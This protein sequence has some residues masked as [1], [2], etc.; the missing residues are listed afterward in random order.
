MDREVL[1]RAF[2][3]FFTTKKMGEGTG[4]G[5]SM[6]YGIVKQSGGHIRLESKPGEGCTFWIYLP[7]VAQVETDVQAPEPPPKLPRGSETILLAEDEGGVRKL[8]ST[9]LRD[10]GY[11]VLTAS[12]GMAGIGVAH[13]YPETIHLLLSDLVMPKLG[14]PELAVELT[15]LMPQLKVIFLSGYA[16]HAVSDIDLALPGARFLAKPLSMELLAR[17]IRDVLDEPPAPH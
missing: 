13:T 3:P 1:A 17:T 8:I 4:L 14:G 12:D 2:E 11:H 6:A 15:R 9:Y 5:L 7:R 10:L 16:G